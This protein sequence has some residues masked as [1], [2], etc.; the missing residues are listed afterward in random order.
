MARLSEKA[1]NPLIAIELGAMLPDWDVTAE[2]TQVLTNRRRAPDILVETGVAPI[3]VETEHAPARTVEDD[4]MRRIGATVDAT[5]QAVES[6]LAVRLPGPLSRVSADQAAAALRVTR[7]F[8]WCAWIEGPRSVRFPSQ[9]WMQGSLADLAAFIETVAVSERRIASLADVFEQGVSQ[10]A[11]RLRWHFVR[12]DG[13]ATLDRIAAALHLQ[14]NEQ[15][16]VIATAV[17]AN[18]LVFQTALSTPLSTPTIEELRRP[19]GVITVADVLAAWRDILDV[20]YWPIFA[21]AAD[22]LKPI[23]EPAG[24]PLLGQLAQTVAEVASGGVLEVGDLAGQMFGKL[25]ADRKF[26]A[27]FYTLPASAALLAELA[28]S[29]LDSLID[30]TDP[31]SVASLKIADFA[32]GTGMLLSAA[33]RRIASRVRR[34]GRITAVDQARLMHSAFMEDVLIGC[35]IMPAAVHLTA[36]ILSA[37]YPSAP[38]GN[39]NIHLMPYGYPEGDRTLGA[40]VGSLELLGDERVR[41]LFGTR[42]VQASGKGD[43]MDN[44][45]TS[46]SFS[47]DNATVDLVIQNP[48]FTR[49]NGP[50]ADRL[51]VP[52]PSFAGFDTGIDEQRAMA[53]RLRHLSPSANGRAGHGNAGLASNFIDLAHAK[54]RPGG[55]LALVLPATFASGDA[56]SAARDLLAREYCDITV[57]TLGAGRSDSRAFSADTGMAEALVVATKRAARDNSAHAGND[58]LDQAMAWVQ[59][60]SLWRRPENPVEAVTAAKSISAALGQ[61]ASRSSDVDMYGYLK[62][63]GHPGDEIGCHISAPLSEGGCAHVTRPLVA[64]AASGLRSGRMRLPRVGTISIP[65]VRLGGLGRAGPQ[66]RVFDD[67]RFRLDAAGNP[68]RDKDGHLV[69]N[70]VFDISHAIEARTPA[71][72]PALWGHDVTSGREQCIVVAP[73]R[74][75]RPWP[76]HQAR[77]D[78]LWKTATRLHF[79]RDF[80]LNSQ[81]LSACIT[82]DS[83]LGGVAWP[84]FLLDQRDFETALAVWANTTLGL[85]GHWW[86][87]TRQQS[88]RARL[89]IKKLPDL[90]T[91]DCRELTAQQLEA[92]AGVFED[93]SDR[94]FR[95]ANEACHDET[96]QQ[97][98]EVVFCD[99]LELDQAAGMSREELLSSLSVL[100]DQWCAEPSVHGDKRASLVAGSGAS[101]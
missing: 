90:P 99:V 87:G 29:R 8:Q 70:G 45:H 75:L 37:A 41:S 36:S 51:D 98:D 20:N 93:F 24:Q 101:G 1:L 3:S 15:T 62:V 33:Y 26:L 43:R 25:I 5:G 21:V 42:R 40:S 100:R 48:P 47:I 67:K 50:E 80:R 91:L 30:W 54:I 68:Q 84:S 44:S 53:L 14:D 77:A 79:N 4:A 97:L 86:V 10:A 7:D 6:A 88:G 83:C 57:V 35:D 2:S 89:S 11:T 78:E 73:D 16:S 34:T 64:A 23:G 22:V 55:V 18:A 13:Q 69:R 17:L 58:E 85:I 39:T 94:A 52:I 82:P 65:T 46:P 9:G 38:F 19:S 27:T 56:W 49:P 12:A 95:P 63:G 71:E 31:R 32:C 61:V 74:D 72:F 92:L 76:G 96:R 59:W 28:V 81:S 60:V 66:N